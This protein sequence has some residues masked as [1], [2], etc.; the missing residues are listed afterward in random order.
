MRGD[1]CTLVRTSDAPRLE[2]DGAY[3]RLAR[4]Q[5]RALFEETANDD[6]WLVRRFSG[7]IQSPEMVPDRQPEDL[8]RERIRQAIDRGDLVGYR[9]IIPGTTPPGGPDDDSMPDPMVEVFVGGPNNTLHLKPAVAKLLQKVFDRLEGGNRG[10]RL[11]V[12]SV[13]FVTKD[14]PVGKAH[15]VRDVVEMSP[16]ELKQE[17]RKQLYVITHELTHV[18]QYNLMPGANPDAR[19]AAMEK[20]YKDEFAKYGEQGQYAQTPELMGISFSSLNV[21]DPRF[22]LEALAR[23]VGVEGHNSLYDR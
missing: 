13:T 14:L 20:R 18:M 15:T 1:E 23:R 8:L 19:W 11:E 6:M 7:E 16:E 17:L 2:R 3:V 5:A 21:V 4:G 10:Y 12:T 22:P 9:Q